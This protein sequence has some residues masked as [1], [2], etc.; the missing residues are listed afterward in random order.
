[1]YYN[2]S[3]FT[4][5]EVKSVETMLAKDLGEGVY[6]FSFQVSGTRGGRRRRIRPSSS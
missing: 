3:M 6:N 5:D 4:E 2:K 1:M